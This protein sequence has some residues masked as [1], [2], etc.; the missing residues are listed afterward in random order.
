[1][2]HTTATPS[3]PPQA[4]RT[5]KSEESSAG[6]AFWDIKAGVKSKGKQLI[7]AVPAVDTPQTSSKKGKAK[8]VMVEAPPPV[9]PVSRT[10]STRNASV[11]GIQETDT[12]ARTADGV[13]QPPRKRRRTADTHPDSASR[14]TLR[15]A[16]TMPDLSSPQTPIPALVSRIPNGQAL[17][18]QTTE[19]SISPV[20]HPIP[21]VK[22]LVRRPPPMYSHPLQKPPPQQHGG[23]L[24]TLLSS[25]VYRNDSE[26]TPEVLQ[27]E[28]SAELALWRKIDALRQHGRLVERCE[29][30]FKGVPPG[31]AWAA[32]VAQVERPW[33]GPGPKFVDGREMAANV[34]GKV[35]KYW[36]MENKVEEARL[37]GL[38]RTAMR[39]VVEQWKKA[40]YVSILVPRLLAGAGVGIDNLRAYV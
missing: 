7:E 21:R 11:A 14:H 3:A 5:K 13:V 31:D 25:F 38:A 17:H 27:A 32:I 28:L 16:A 33:P 24:D 22:L 9:T 37:K 2:V 12:P 26:I 29:Y 10:K 39:M 20:K 35:R 4:R 34:A 18:A 36:E 8:L 30:A 15:S 40:V 23:S 1:M 19:P 6:P